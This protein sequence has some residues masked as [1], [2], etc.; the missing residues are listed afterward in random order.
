MT[1]TDV[2]AIGYIAQGLFSARFIVQWISSEKA[3]KVVAPT[4]FWQIS[5][6][7]SFLLVVYSI[8]TKDITILGGQMI[9]YYIYVR[10]LRLQEAWRI[11]P[12]YFRLFVLIVPIGAVLTLLFGGQYS[13]LSMMGNHQNI[14]LLAWGLTGQA[15]FSCRFI[16]QWYYSEKVKKIRH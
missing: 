13:F 12:L 7:A 16:Y 11:L 1:G 10:N 3:G 15:I 9:G 14:W 2:N 6:I 8:L 4:L 5:L